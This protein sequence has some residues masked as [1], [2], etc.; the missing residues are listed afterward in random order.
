MN[1]LGHRAVV[2][3]LEHGLIGLGV[4]PSGREP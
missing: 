1:S 3:A 4:L 2:V